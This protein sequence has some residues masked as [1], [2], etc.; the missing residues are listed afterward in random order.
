MAIKLSTFPGMKNRLKG[1]S[2]QNAVK[3]Q[4]VKRTLMFRKISS[5]SFYAQKYYYKDC[6]W[7]ATCVNNWIA[8]VYRYRILQ[9]PFISSALLPLIV[10]LSFSRKFAVFY[11]ILL[12]VLPSLYPNSMTNNSI[13]YNGKTSMVSCAMVLFQNRM[14]KKFSGNFSN[15]NLIHNYKIR[16]AVILHTLYQ[17]M[18][19][20]TENLW[21]WC[22]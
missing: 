12:Y 5:I 8:I 9:N 6:R 15:K 4:L 19:T 3:T 10:L 17:R 13:H 20:N 11:H 22:M 7:S 21:I 18:Q 1:T 14:N 16:N 2:F